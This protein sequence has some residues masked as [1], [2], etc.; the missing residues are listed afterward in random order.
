MTQT[1]EARNSGNVIRTD[2]EPLVNTGSSDL[3]SDTL[4]CSLT[5]L[6]Y[7]CLCHK[8]HSDLSLSIFLLQTS[9]SHISIN[10]LT[11]LTVLMAPESP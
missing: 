4:D 8:L 1:G 6:L 3:L 9:F 7:L 10:S 5:F 2:I 11:I